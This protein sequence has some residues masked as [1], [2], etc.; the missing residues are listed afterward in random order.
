MTGVVAVVAV[1]SI[2]IQLVVFAVVAAVDVVV[3][4]FISI[5]LVDSG[6][7]RLCRSGICLCLIYFLLLLVGRVY[8]MLS[9]NKFYCIFFLM[10]ALFVGSWK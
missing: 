1:V 9:C 8:V 3:V 7:C 4:V 5:Q 6:T 10:P 2:S